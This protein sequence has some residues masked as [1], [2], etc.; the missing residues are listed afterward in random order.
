MG[1]DDIAPDRKMYFSRVASMVSSVVA[2]QA[3]RQ[4]L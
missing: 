3:V 1:F 4:N 2:E